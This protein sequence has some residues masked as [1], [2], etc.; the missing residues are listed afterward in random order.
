MKSTGKT[1]KNAEKG[2][3]RENN[4]DSENTEN[5]MEKRMQINIKITR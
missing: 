5:R 1:W 4:V 3:K 2:E